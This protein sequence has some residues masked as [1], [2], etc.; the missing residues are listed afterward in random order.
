MS[1]NCIFFFIFVRTSCYNF[2]LCQNSTILASHFICFPRELFWAPFLSG[3][4]LQLHLWRFQIQIAHVGDIMHAAVTRDSR[5]LSFLIL[6]ELH[7]S[8]ISLSLTKFVWTILTVFYSFYLGDP[9]YWVA[10]DREKMGQHGLNKVGGRC[11]YI[12][13]DIKISRCVVCVS[14]SLFE[15]FNSDNDFFNMVGAGIKCQKLLWK[16]ISWCLCDGWIISVINE[17]NGLYGKKMAKT[18]NVWARA[19]SWPPILRLNWKNRTC[20]ESIFIFL[21][22]EKWDFIESWF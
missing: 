13:M 1:F 7:G 21:M 6:M 9:S 19:F 17:L 10:V 20:E 18:K 15:H 16:C 22:Y 2:F 11:N 4:R 12:R 5:R 14:V 3:L 8:K